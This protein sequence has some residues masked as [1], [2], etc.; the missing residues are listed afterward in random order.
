MMSV[1]V[2][3]GA[4]SL[5]LG[6]PKPL[7]QTRLEL[8]LDSSSRQCVS[9]DGQRFLLA[10]SLEESA[11]VPITVIVNWLELLKKGAAP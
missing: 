5:K 3:S 6:V 11:S 4:A 10:Q 8:L 7:F 2:D 9:A 1:P